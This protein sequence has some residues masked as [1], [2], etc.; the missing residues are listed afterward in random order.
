MDSVRKQDSPKRIIIR[1]IFQDRKEEEMFSRLAS[2][3]NHEEETNEEKD[4]MYEIMKKRLV[5]ST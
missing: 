3:Y 1:V 5:E 2:F 4:K